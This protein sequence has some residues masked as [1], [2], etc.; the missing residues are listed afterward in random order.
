[1]RESQAGERVSIEH[2]GMGVRQ[3]ALNL[4]GKVE[5]EAIV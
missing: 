1:V 3:L 5:E 4:D 2:W